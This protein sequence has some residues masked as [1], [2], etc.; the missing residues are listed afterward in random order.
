MET[1]RNIG[2]RKTKY[3]CIVDADESTRPRVEGA[4]H[5]T[6]QDHITAKG[7]NS[8]THYSLVHKFIPMPQAMQLPD[9]K[10][11]VEKE[12]RKL[13]KIPAWQ[14]T[15]VRNRNEVIAEART[16]G[17]TVHQWISVI[18]RIRSWSHSFKNTKV[19]LRGDVVKDDSGSNAVF[20]EQGS[21]VSQ[22]TAAKVM[23]IISRLPGRAG[24]AADA[25]SG[26][27]GRC[28]DVTKNS[29]VRISRYLDTSTKTQM[30][31]IMFQHGRSSRSS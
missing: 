27:N 16:K 28:T 15:K 30:A 20:T 10:A 26:Q 14:Q 3:A 22:M 23:D 18:S 8:M 2:K 19:V 12:W 1:H 13:E 6:H 7:M 31:Q 5:Q 29:K 21:S 17:H 24:Q 11:A 25:V 4:V 9:A